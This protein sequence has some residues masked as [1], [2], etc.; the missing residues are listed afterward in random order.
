MAEPAGIDVICPKHDRWIVDFYRESDG[1]WNSMRVINVGEDDVKTMADE[2]IY[3]EEAR[4]VPIETAIR[5]HFLDRGGALES[6]HRGAVY[7]A[8]VRTA[9]AWEITGWEIECAPCRRDRLRVRTARFEAVLNG[10]VSQG[11]HEISLDALARLYR[12]ASSV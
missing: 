11:I 7:R 10:L 2:A 1:S 4:G 8:R 9:T 3:V 12:R 6:R 5:R